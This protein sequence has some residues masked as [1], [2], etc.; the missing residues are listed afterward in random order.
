MENFSNYYVALNNST[1]ETDCELCEA[2]TDNGGSC[3]LPGDCPL[4]IGYYFKKR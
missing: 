1:Y 4:K 3:P 2:K